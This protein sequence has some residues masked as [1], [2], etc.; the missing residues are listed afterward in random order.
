MKSKMNDFNN[1]KTFAPLRLC[2]NLYGLCV[3]TKQRKSKLSL[4]SAREPRCEND[5]EAS[6][7]MKSSDWTLWKNFAPLRENLLRPL[8]EKL[9]ASAPCEN[10]C[11]LCVKTLEN[12]MN[13]R[14]EKI[15]PP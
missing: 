11:G 4:G 6:E 14:F 9:C 10:L 5:L 2:E 7:K 13:P 3:K 15:V 12:E 8:R 1:W